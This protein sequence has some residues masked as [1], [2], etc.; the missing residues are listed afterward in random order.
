MGVKTLYD[1]F[2]KLAYGDKGA[3]KATLVNDCLDVADAEI[4]ANKDAKH[5]HSNKTLLDTYTQIEVD[6]ED[7]VT[8][9]H[10]HSNK[11]ELDKLTDGDHDVRTDNP[12]TVT[13][14]Q[15]GYSEGIW[16]LALKFGGNSVGMTYTIQSG[17]YTRIGRMLTITGIIEL[18]AKGTSTGDATITGLPFTC[19]NTLG[20]LSVV[21]LKITGV[22]FANIYQGFILKDTATIYLRE[23]TEAGVETT[24]NNNNFANNSSI[25]LTAT[26]F[27]D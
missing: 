27:T 18:S 4:K 15:L 20:A 6:L 9:K 21:L 19:K 11:T 1:Y 26:Y 22:T 5:T 16:T 13:K 25:I 17:L 12:H 24:L 3:D 14:E 2:Y 10:T 23:V 7:A 8:K